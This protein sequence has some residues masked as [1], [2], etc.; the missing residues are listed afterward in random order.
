MNGTDSAFTPPLGTCDCQVHVFGD[1]RVYPPVANRSYDP[2]PATG[3]ELAA[4]HQRSG[5]DRVVIVQATIY[6]NDHRALLDALRGRCNFRG[7]ATV[8]D[9]ISDAE[10]AVLHQAGVRGARFGL[11]SSIQTALSREEFAR[12]V[13]RIQV[14]GWH[15]KILAS[16]EDLEKY[17]SWLHDLTLPVVLDHLGGMHPGHALEGPG[18]DVLQKLLWKQNFWIML[19][20][21]DRR[22]VQ[23]PPWDDMVPIIRAVLSLAPDRAIWGTDW[24]HVR[25]ANPIVP[26]IA[27]LLTFLSRAIPE[28][29]S[30]RKV[31]VD[32]PARLYG[33][34]D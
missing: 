6:G 25:Y 12:S 31:L 30:I 26:Q 4:A 8:N 1:V 17:Q 32:N 21:S 11:G 27:D 5:V 18:F 28:Q 13:S 33:F 19:S 15:A 9:E 23:G 20:N 22:S 29:N 34:V 14:L 3:Q 16:L 24:P 7:V 2:P 10:L